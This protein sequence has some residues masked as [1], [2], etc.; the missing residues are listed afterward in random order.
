MSKPPRR[1]RGLWCTP[2]AL[3]PIPIEPGTTAG[4]GTQAPDSPPDLR[5]KGNIHCP[6]G[7]S[8]RRPRR[9][10]RCGGTD[11]VS[12]SAHAFCGAEGGIA[13]AQGVKSG[14]ASLDSCGRPGDLPGVEGDRLVPV[15]VEEVATAQMPAVLRPL[16]F[17]DLFGMGEEQA[18]QVLLAAVRPSG[19]PVRKPGFPGHVT[20]AGLS[21]LGGPGPRLPGSMPRVWN[22][23]AR[24]PGFTGRDRLLVAPRER[25]LSGDRAVVQAPA[26]HGWVGQNAANG[27]TLARPRGVK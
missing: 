11:A 23:P 6:A 15:R 12:G 19:R 8:G 20:A 2:S 1:N 21:R 18:R 16:L 3:P 10:A 24:N 25:L 4:S 26:W 9:P 14:N 5:Q 27:L 7:I 22:V 13:G 17:R